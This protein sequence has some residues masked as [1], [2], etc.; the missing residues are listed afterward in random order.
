MQACAL[1]HHPT[2]LADPFC[3]TCGHPRIAESLE[4]PVKRPPWLDQAILAGAAVVGVWLIITA[5]VAF[6][7]EA[8]ALRWARAALEANDAG[9]AYRLV[10]PFV[11]SHPRHAEALF[12]AG[13]S[14]IKTGRPQEAVAHYST[15]VSLGEDKD[16]IER[17]GRLEAVYQKQILMNASRL[18]CGQSGYAQLYEAYATLGEPFR[19]TLF[20]SAASVASKCVVTGSRRKLNEPAY[21]LIHEKNLDPESVVTALY[22]EPLKPTLE[23][24]QYQLARELARQGMSQWPQVKPQIDDIFSETRN[25]VARTVEG[26]QHLC[27][28]LVEDPEFRQGRSACFP[29]SPPAAVTEQQDG[30]GNP[31]AYTPL[32]LRA[33]TQCYRGFELISLGADGKRT[34]DGALTAAMEISCR[35]ERG[36]QRLKSPDRFWF[37][38]K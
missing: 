38:G 23:R 5:G 35:Y 13:S 20:R 30:W 10:S 33:E 24:G 18:D 1:C 2:V 15:L 29:A 21:W 25:R 34:P 4:V 16:A 7:R 8:K 6:L 17:T 28:N 32:A 37:P 9:R 26:I 3:A 12:L 27:A 22:V 14:A 19:D 31:V 36:R 11:A